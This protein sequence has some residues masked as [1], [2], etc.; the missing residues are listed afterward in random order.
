MEITLDGITIP[1]EVE[2]K[3]EDTSA[4]EKSVYNSLEH[5]RKQLPAGLPGMICLK[6]PE[7]WKGDPAVP[8]VFR[9]INR[10]FRRTERV[11]AVVVR[12]ERHSYSVDDSQAPESAALLIF[13]RNHSSRLLTAT[14]SAA[15]DRI[16]SGQDRFG[17]TPLAAL[18]FA[19]NRLNAARATF[20]TVPN[21]THDFQ[22][23]RNAILNEIRTELAQ[24]DPP[25]SI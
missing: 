6:I 3:E 16:W 11:V 4:T 1:C 21:P 7:L 9:T 17:G 24:H 10:F 15:L 19:L 18:A 22:T 12:S 13:R 5:A 20:L 8:A 25:L 14:V 23:V 2:G